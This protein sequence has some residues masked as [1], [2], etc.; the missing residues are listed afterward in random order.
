M[1]SRSRKVG[2]FRSLTRGSCVP[3]RCLILASGCDDM[4]LPMT[5]GKKSVICSRS[6]L[7]DHPSVPIGILSMPCCTLQKRERL[8]AIFLDDLENGKRCTADSATGRGEMF[9]GIFSRLPLSVM[10]KSEASL[11]GR[12]FVHIRMR[13]EEGEV[14]KKRHRKISRRLLQQGPRGRRHQWQTTGGHNHSRSA[15]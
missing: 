1:L 13:R 7:G 14:P 12:S 11:T 4:S 9:G 5:N 8:G 2:S 3:I 6:V 15:T 10:T